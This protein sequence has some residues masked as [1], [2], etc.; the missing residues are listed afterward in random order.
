MLQLRSLRKSY[1]GGKSFVVDGIDLDVEAGSRL[2]L[3][4]GSGCG[5]TTTLKMIN[6]LV[7]PSSGSIL[8]DGQDVVAMDPIAL[9]RS[10][11]YVFQNIGLFPHLTVA[12]NI[13]VVPD[14]LGWP[15]ERTQARVREL[16][17]LIHLPPDSFARRYPGELSGGQRQRVGFARALAARPRLL[18]MDEPFGALD[19]ITRDQLQEDFKQIQRE[20]GFTVVMVTHDMTEA[21]LLGDQIA[22]MESGHIAQLGTPRQ[23]LSSPSTDFVRELME[24]PRRQAAFLESLL[25]EEASH[26]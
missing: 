25:R 7:E 16:L 12:Q 26:V 6:R 14:L 20:L 23:L 8:M 4:G 5:K 3:L 15:Q 24:T 10:V 1:D 19:P 18:L 9:R 21:L 13:G 11:G 17:E 22:V 2:V